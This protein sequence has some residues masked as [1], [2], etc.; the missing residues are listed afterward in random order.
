MTTELTRRSLVA[1][2]IAAL[3]LTGL[4]AMAEASGEVSSACAVAENRPMTS[5]F[6]ASTMAIP[7]GKP[8]TMQA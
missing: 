6:T 8:A 5:P 4:P 2:G 3:S 1:L 7:A